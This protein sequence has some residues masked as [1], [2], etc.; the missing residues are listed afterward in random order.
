MDMVVVLELSHGKEIIPII[1]SFIHEEVKVLL[2]FLV[3]LF[4]LT[5]HLWVIGSRGCNEESVQLTS[6]FKTNCTPLSETTTWGSIR[7]GSLG[8]VARN[9]NPRDVCEGIA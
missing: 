7:I 2:Q 5:I 6:E 9:L 4:G 3:D 8:I 1:L